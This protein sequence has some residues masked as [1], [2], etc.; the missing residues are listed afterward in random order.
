[1]NLNSSA[2]D[3]TH[4][5]KKYHS[6]TQIFALTKDCQWQ[7]VIEHGLRHLGE[8]PEDPEVLPYV[9]YALF[10]N[11]NLPASLEIAKYCHS[12]LPS[13]YM[14]SYVKNFKNRFEIR[15]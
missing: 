7:A 12:A 6:R 15:G 3:A 13:S 9:A 11:K 2:D 1:M 14:T 5:A 10:N 8:F 4:L